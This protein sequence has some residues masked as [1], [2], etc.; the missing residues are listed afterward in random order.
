[1]LTFPIDNTFHVPGDPRSL[2]AQVSFSFQPS[3]SR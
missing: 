2:G 1:V 3:T